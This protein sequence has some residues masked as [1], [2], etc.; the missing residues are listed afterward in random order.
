MLKKVSESKLPFESHSVHKVPCLTRLC[1][2]IVQRKKTVTSFNCFGFLVMMP[3]WFLFPL[4]VYNVWFLYWLH[5]HV[6]PK[7]LA[8]PTVT[9]TSLVT[10]TS[11]AWPLQN[12]FL[13]PW[14]GSIMY[15]V[16]MPGTSQKL[17]PL[18]MQF[19]SSSSGVL[20]DISSKFQCWL[21]SRFN[22]Q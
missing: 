22:T 20:V 19:T 15:P 16:S 21:L 5:A 6:T 12:F 7:L 11:G 3:L 1:V 2:E 4:H 13:R 10:P 18:L 8:T 14:T 9:L 17:I